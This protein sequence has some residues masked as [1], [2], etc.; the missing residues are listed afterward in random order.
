MVSKYMLDELHD[1]F[2]RLAAIGGYD[3]YGW[4]EDHPEYVELELVSLADV[5]EICPTCESPR[6]RCELLTSVV[7]VCPV[8]DEGD[9]K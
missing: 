9:T 2:A 3:E 4:V 6:R 8:C 5:P 7:W 1:V